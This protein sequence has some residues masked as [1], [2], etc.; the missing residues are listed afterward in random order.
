MLQ[1][2]VNEYSCFALLLFGVPSLLIPPHWA[3]MTLALAR[4]SLPSA[5]FAFTHLRSSTARLST[6]SSKQD[7]S[8]LSFLDKARR[9]ARERASLRMLS[10][11]AEGQ[12]SDE[13]ATA[14]DV[15]PPPLSAPARAAA[16]VAGAP[17]GR[18]DDPHPPKKLLELSASEHRYKLAGIDMTP[19][20]GLPDGLTDDAILTFLMETWDA[21]KAGPPRR[22]LYKLQA[23]VRVRVRVRVSP[24]TKTPSL[25]LTLTCTSPQPKPKPYPDVHI[26][27]P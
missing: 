4:R 17:R 2:G 25:S 12:S 22:K 15:R 1:N 26:P 7:G 21:P 16:A 27:S 24:D 3:V 6:D 8:V 10:E 5:R 14:D 23:A 11:K 19:N 20:A 13:S 9:A 18:A